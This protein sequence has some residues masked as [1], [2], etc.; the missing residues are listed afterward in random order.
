[1]KKIVINLEEE[2]RY[3]TV[4]G[5]SNFTRADEWFL[6]DLLDWLMISRDDVNYKERKT[7]NEKKEKLE[8]M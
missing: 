7:K 4:Y 1:M 5:K 2:N 8:N 3:I 6:T